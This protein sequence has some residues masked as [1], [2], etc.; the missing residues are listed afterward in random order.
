MASEATNKAVRGNFLIDFR[1][2][3]SLFI[4]SEQ[5]LTSEAARSIFILVSPWFSRRLLIFSVQ[6]GHPLSVQGAH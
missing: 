5:D 3:L 6:M 1:I 2:W 4:I